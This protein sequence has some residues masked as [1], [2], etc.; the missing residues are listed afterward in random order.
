[1]RILKFFSSPNK[2]IFFVIY[3][4]LA[5]LNVLLLHSLELW[6]Q[7]ICNSF[8]TSYYLLASELK[9]ISYPANHISAPRDLFY[10]LSVVICNTRRGTC[11]GFVLCSFIRVTNILQGNFHCAFRRYTYEYLLHMPM[12]FRAPCS[13]VARQWTVDILHVYILNVDF[14]GIERHVKANLVS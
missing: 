8:V 11:L 4:F 14:S 13:S 3:D 9:S 2:V 7:F 12:Y 1:M 5:P 10:C 6:V